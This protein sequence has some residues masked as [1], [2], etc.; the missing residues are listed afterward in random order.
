MDSVEFKWTAELCP[1]RCAR[2]R[3]WGAG[4]NGCMLR[5][6]LASS[7]DSGLWGDDPDAA[8]P[9]PGVVRTI[10]EYALEHGWNPAVV[11]GRHVLGVD[12]DLQIPG[13]HIIDL[14]Q[15]FQHLKN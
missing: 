10:A 2:L 5:V 9:T 14:L 1:P 3:V 13:F 15:G 12:A 8:Y 6:D 11:G 4:K 7:A